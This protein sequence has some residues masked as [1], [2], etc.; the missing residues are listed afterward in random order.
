MIKVDLHSHSTCSDGTFAPAHVVTL[1]HEMGIDVFALTD[2]DTTFGIDEARQMASEL[3]MCLIDGVEISC[4]HQINGGY[5][6]NKSTTKTIHVV[7]LNFK[8]K[9][10]LNQKL[11]QL[12]NSRETRGHAILVK[13]AGILANMA[14]FSHIDERV[15]WQAVLNKANGNTKA[16]GRAHIGQVLFEMGV[17][18]TVQDAFDKYLAD[19]K[20][21]YVAIDSLTMGQTIELIHKCGGISV[22]AHPTRY[23]LSATRVR[24]LIS[25]FSMLGGQAVELPSSGEPIST[26]TMI[27]RCVAEHGLMVSVGSDFHGAN[28]PWRKLGQV[29]IPKAGQVGVWER[30]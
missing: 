14:D 2:H 4:H 10:Q 20:P 29:A 6:K 15:L 1:A 3:G 23:G 11:N 25:D 30:F 8:D 12:Q 28:M 22:L 18:R 13:M 7:A 24:R 9:E 19:D 21:A 27:D 17:V 16:V 26:R 5:G